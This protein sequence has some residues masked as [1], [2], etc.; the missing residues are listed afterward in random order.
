MDF[1]SISIDVGDHPHSVLLGIHV[2]S[3]GGIGFTIAKS[4]KPCDDGKHGTA[5]AD[6][7]ALQKSFTNWLTRLLAGTQVESAMKSGWRF[8]FLARASIVTFPIRGR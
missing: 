5:L 7:W 8:S 6:H 1:S 4:S 2:G 3:F